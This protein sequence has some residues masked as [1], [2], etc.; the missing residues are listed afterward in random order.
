[1]TRCS[2]YRSRPDADCPPPRISRR[3]EF[4]DKKLRRIFGLP[5]VESWILWQGS[6]A[7]PDLT[8]WE[9]L[10]RQPSNCADGFDPVDLL[11]RFGKRVEPAALA[12]HGMPLRAMDPARI[13]A[14]EHIGCCF[15]IETA[16]PVVFLV[17]GLS[18]CDYHSGDPTQ[19]WRLLHATLLR[20]WSDRGNDA[21]LADEARAV[22]CG[23]YAKTI[24]NAARQH[25]EA[26]DAATVIG[27]VF[28]GWC[29]CWESD[30]P[31]KLEYVV[32][33]SKS[34]DGFAAELCPGSAFSPDS[35][36]EGG[37]E[38]HPREGVTPQDAVYGFESGHFR[39]RRKLLE[40]L[41]FMDRGNIPLCLF[42]FQGGQLLFVKRNHL[43]QAPPP[44]ERLL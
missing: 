43:T 38:Q 26:Y 11:R 33:W 16:F 37:L 30:M 29:S 20:A 39:A 32:V 28:A 1:M 40:P 15:M 34:K 31:I 12:D 27:T 23:P 6:H 21:K 10:I 14:F 4:V 25:R 13:Q 35:F 44:G 5:E 7:T 41:E 36:I 42:S 8:K 3:E 19:R 24:S 2:V 22:L 9:T 18:I 17:E